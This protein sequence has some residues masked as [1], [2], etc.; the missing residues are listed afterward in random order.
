MSLLTYIIGSLLIRPSADVCCQD[1]LAKLI[2]PRN[3]LL[4]F[5]LV[6]QERNLGRAVHFEM[7]LRS[8]KMGCSIYWDRE[9]DG[10]APKPA[11]VH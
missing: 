2:D 9:A 3:A 7:M 8:R 11:R 6:M 1:D 10:D 5:E 4:L